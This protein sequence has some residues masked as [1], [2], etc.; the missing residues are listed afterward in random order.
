MTQR[1]T[2]LRTEL[3]STACSRRLRVLTGNAI[4]LAVATQTELATSGRFQDL[5][6]PEPQGLA[7]RDHGN[8][9]TVEGE[10]RAVLASHRENREEGKQLVSGWDGHPQGASTQNRHDRPSEAV[11]GPQLAAR[12]T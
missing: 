2:C 6:E 7:S 1:V 8:W 10:L 3:R 5:S 4:R 9:I 11:N 12:T